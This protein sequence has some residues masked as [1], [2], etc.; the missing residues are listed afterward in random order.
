MWSNYIFG[1]LD[2]NYCIFFNL[3]SIIGMFLALILLVLLFLYPKLFKKNIFFLVILCLILYFQNRI[4]YNMCINKKHIL[5]AN[6]VRVRK[7]FLNAFKPKSNNVE[8]I[9]FKDARINLSGGEVSRDLVNQIK[10]ANNA[11]NEKY[12]TIQNN[13]TYIQSQLNRIENNTTPLQYISKTN[14]VN[15]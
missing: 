14:I 15:S 3:I 2:V 1:N 13:V 10:N 9:D 11:W 12:P 6:T 4:L 7:N 8:K 5:E